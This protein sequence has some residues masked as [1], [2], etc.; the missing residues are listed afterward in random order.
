MTK[1][2]EKSRDFSFK[3]PGI[4]ADLKSRDPGNPGIPL[5]PDPRSPNTSDIYPSSH[6]SSSG[7][8]A[9]APSVQLTTLFCPRNF[10]K[11]FLHFLLLILLRNEMWGWTWYIPHQTVEICIQITFALSCSAVHSWWEI[12]GENLKFSFCL[13]LR[14]ATIM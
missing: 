13:C 12:F 1:N 11:G 5:G 7:I 2:P 6:S 3:N 4:L 9:S 10:L 8:C 14:W